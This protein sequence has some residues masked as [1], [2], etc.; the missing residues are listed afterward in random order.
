[1][2][3]G[4]GSSVPWKTMNSE[5]QIAEI[6]E[7]SHEKPQLIFKH[8]T[9]C[10]I[11]SMAKSRLER[12]WNLENLEPWYLDLIAFRNIS[13]AIASQLG[14]HHESPQAIVLKDGVVV[15]DAS[16]NSISVSEIAK[17]VS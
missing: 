1:M 11:S 17:R 3:S 16:H 15:Y 7:L 14:V 10:S 6:V 5:R 13:N 12:E 2:F 8:S 9:R 4:G